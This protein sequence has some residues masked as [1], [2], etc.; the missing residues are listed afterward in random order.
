MAIC[1]QKGDEIDAVLLKEQDWHRLSMSQGT[2]GP[3]MFDWAIVP[4][5]HQGVVDGCRLSPDPSLSR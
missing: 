4:V 1:W 5:V 2:K 3:R